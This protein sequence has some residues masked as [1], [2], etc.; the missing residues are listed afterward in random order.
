LGQEELVLIESSRRKLIHPDL[1]FDHDQDDQTTLGFFKKQGKSAPK[2]VQRFFL[3]EIY[4]IF[5]AVE[6][7]WGARWCRSIS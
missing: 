7:G 6:R 4:A 1:Y 5:D 3:D 2:V